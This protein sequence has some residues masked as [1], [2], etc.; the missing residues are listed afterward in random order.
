MRFGF[1]LGKD[2]LSHNAKHLR[3][4]Q[5]WLVAIRIIL[6]LCATL[7][8]DQTIVFRVLLAILF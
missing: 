4:G 7:A 6:N 1:D 5:A 3:V 8:I 2:L